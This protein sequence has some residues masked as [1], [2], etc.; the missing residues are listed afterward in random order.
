MIECYSTMIP[1]SIMFCK[2]D[3]NIPK[4]MGTILNQLISIMVSVKA[5]ISLTK[6][7]RLD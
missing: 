3:K 2:R 1:P 4:G 6:R 5:N 7:T